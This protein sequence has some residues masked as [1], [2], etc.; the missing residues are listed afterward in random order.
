MSAFDEIELLFGKL[1]LEVNAILSESEL[2]EI[3][4]FI[5]VGEYGLALQTAV[6]IFLE[7]GKTLTSKVISL[8]VQLATAMSMESEILEL[9]SSAKKQEE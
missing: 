1:L 7:E 4:S 6:D 9:L 8:M 3:R 2:T 5:D